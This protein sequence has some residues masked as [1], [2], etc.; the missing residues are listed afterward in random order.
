MALDAAVHVAV[1]GLLAGV[2]AA[3]VMEP[4]LIELVGSNLT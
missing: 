1:D 3:S 2:V 4:S